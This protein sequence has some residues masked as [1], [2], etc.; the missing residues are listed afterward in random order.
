VASE[1]FAIVVV[2][3]DGGCVVFDVVDAVN[4][5][6]AVVVVVGAAPPNEKD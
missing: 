3:V 2:D 1:E 5:G 4:D 6:A